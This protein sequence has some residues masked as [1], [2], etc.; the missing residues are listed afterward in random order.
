MEILHLF[1]TLVLY[2][3]LLVLILNS[4]YA[5]GWR[6]ML[7]RHVFAPRSYYTW[8]FPCTTFA[9]LPLVFHLHPFFPLLPYSLALP[10]AATCALCDRPFALP[11]QDLHTPLLPNEV[12][13]TYNLLSTS[14]YNRPTDYIPEWVRHK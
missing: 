6:L 14:S 3:R 12:L 13:Q 9:L 2:C 8:Y 1:L 5:C 10:Q 11:I 4:R 7:P